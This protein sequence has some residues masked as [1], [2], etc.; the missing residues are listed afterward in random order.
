MRSRH[1]SI[2]VEAIIVT[3]RLR[4]RRRICAICGQTGRHL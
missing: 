1:V 4:R 2:S 3:V